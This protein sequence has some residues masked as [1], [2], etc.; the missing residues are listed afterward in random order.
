MKCGKK[1]HTTIYKKNPLN[2]ENSSK[3]AN[4]TASADTSTKPNPSQVLHASIHPGQ[5][6]T[7][8]ILLAT[9]QVLLVNEK[10]RIMKIRALLD[11]GSEVTLIS[12]RAV[13]TLRLPRSQTFIPLIG[14]GEQSSNR[15]RG[16]TTFKITSLYN[17]E[18][19]I[20]AHILKKLT[21]LIPSDQI[22]GK[23]WSH[24]EGLSLADP[25]FGS[26]GSIDLLIGADIYPQIIKEGLGK[27]SLD[28]PIAQLTSIGWVISGP[29]SS[30]SSLLSARSYHISMDSQLYDLLHRFWQLEEITAN[31]E[32]SMT[33]ENQDCEQQ[34]KDTHSRDKKGRYVV[35]L[36]FKKSPQLLGNSFNRATKMME[37]LRNKL[38]S[39]I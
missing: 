29:V 38:K 9:A 25:Q 13:Q 26:P 2:A 28:A 21:N 1:H 22:I 15:T 30:E 16:I 33:P 18:F 31:R 34:F 12:E 32:S 8:C 19:Q 20:S 37:S 5:N 11:Q 27:G 14:V 23:S 3:R 39:D 24:L 36:P 10:G 6:S 35:R 7:T 17:S 4:L